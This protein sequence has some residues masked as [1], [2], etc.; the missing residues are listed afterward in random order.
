MRNIPARLKADTKFKR[1][2]LS[3]YI[4][5]RCKN[6]KAFAFAAKAHLTIL[7]KLSLA[8]AQFAVVI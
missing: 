2:S 3:F 6:N 4:K 1:S 7:A 8:R 5:I